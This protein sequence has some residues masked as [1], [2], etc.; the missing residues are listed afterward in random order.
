MIKGHKI[1]GAEVSEKH[2]NFIINS[3]KATGE[4][5]VSL[6]NYVHDKVKNKTEVD[7]KIEQEIIDWE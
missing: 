3:D 7:L 6:M 2:A 5:V 1:G 4:D